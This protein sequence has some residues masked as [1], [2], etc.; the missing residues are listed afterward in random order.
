M[1]L[2]IILPVYNV[3]KFLPDCLDSLLC[4]DIPKEDYEIIC[5]NDGSPDSSAEVIEEYIKLHNNIRLISQPNSGVC[6]ARNTGFENAVGKY[7]W[8][9][10]PD[11]YVAPNCLGKILN[12]M[13]E[14]NADLITF[15]YFNVEEES[16]FNPEAKTQIEI[17][18]Q[19]GYS[20]KGG[21]CQYI[22]RSQY[23]LDN[24]IIYNKELAYG[25]DYLWAFQINYRKHVGLE[26]KSEVY[27][28]RQRQGSAMHNKSEEKKRRHQ[29]DMWAL[30]KIYG[31][32]Y[33]RCE[34]EE[35]PKEVLYN[36]KQRQI[37]CC[38]SVIFDLIKLS[39]DKREVKETLAKLKQDGLYPYKITWWQL[40]EKSLVGGLK[41]K[42]FFLLFP[43]KWYVKLMAKIFRKKAKK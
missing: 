37:L 7:V 23:L 34:R 8:F 2:S 3:A 38:Q 13:E 42:L 40:R 22:C 19:I 18:E 21:G 26:T 14:K 31:E 30:A 29:Q 33:K 17:K 1:R 43:F 27:Y 20:S 12:A 9:I 41:N 11:D 36:V 28:Y 35:L 4:Q 5:V 15:D 25:K 16:R 24:G 10:D 6:V 39:K 32:E